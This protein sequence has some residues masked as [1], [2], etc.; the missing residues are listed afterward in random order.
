MHTT[1]EIWMRAPAAKVFSLA[2]DVGR[3]PELL[4]HYRRV[5]VI[6]GVCGPSTV[7]MAA[8]RG[9]FPV[10]WTAE[11]RLLP[12]ERRILYLHTRGVT[13]GMEVEWRIAERDGGCQVV[14]EH[15]LTSRNPLLRTRL[16]S[17][18]VGELFVRAVAGQT[19][20]HIRRAA[21]APGERSA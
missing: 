1:N 7:E 16:A 12:A 10:S 6:A 3:W 20:E 5:R 9:W 2:A 18:V 19:L 11:Q 13:A 17:W 4:P 8:R 15:R 21:E 14:I